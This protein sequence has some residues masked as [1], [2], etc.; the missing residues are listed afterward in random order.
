MKPASQSKTPHS[1]G[2]RMPAEWELHEA[3]WLGWPRELTDWPGKFAPIPWAFAEIVRQLSRVER[4]HLLVQDAAAEKRVKSAL[5]KTGAHLD[6]VSFFRVPTDRGWMRD[7]GPICVRSSG[8]EVAF[9]HFVFNGWAKYSNHK[10]DA[11]AV[12][13]VNRQ[14]KHRVWQP[15]YK[16]RRVVL[17]GGSIDV[18]GRGTLLTTEECLLSKMQERNPGF[19]REDYAEVFREYLGVTNVL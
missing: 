17:E 1:L 5:K 4:V 3:T 14:L 11:V 8:G 10:R 19:T 2:F 12:E 7:S 18:N 16:G 15:I 13:K 6:A 9:N